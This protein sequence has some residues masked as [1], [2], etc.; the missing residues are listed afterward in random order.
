MPTV[1]A[2][3]AVRNFSDLLNR[4]RYRGESFA[5]ERNGQVVARITGVAPATTARALVERLGTLPADDDF[6][7][8]LERVQADQPPLG[9]DPWGT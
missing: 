1:T 2:T 7:D 4:I 3:E 8:D 6:A 5:I 9:D